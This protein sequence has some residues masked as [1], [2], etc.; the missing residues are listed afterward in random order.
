MF[1]KKALVIWALLTSCPCG[2]KLYDIVYNYLW[3][4]DGKH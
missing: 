2:Q 3:L 1:G 4:W